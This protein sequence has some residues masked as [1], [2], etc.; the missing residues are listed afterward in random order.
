M[1]PLVAL[2]H[3]A[4]PGLPLD[5]LAGLTLLAAIPFVL[6]TTTSFIRI[7]VVL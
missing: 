1:G 7:V 3:D 2:A 6:V 4:H 5:I